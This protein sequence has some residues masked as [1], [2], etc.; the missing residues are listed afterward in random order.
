MAEIYTATIDLTKVS[1]KNIYE[2]KSGAR[3]L[4]IRF[5]IYDQPDKEGTDLLIG[6]VF[7]KEN[8]RNRDG[9]FIVTPILGNG[10]HKK[11]R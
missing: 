11:T 2:T 4:N 5:V 10:I 9:E 3:L 1:E 6:Q 8:Q 7:M